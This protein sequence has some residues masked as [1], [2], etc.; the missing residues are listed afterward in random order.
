MATAKKKS[1]SKKSAP[2]AKKSALKKSAPKAKKSAPKVK[3]KPS[4]KQIAQRAKIG[5]MGKTYTAA[6]NEK[7]AGRKVSAAD[8]A[9]AK[10]AGRR[11][12]KAMK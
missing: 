12:V 6:Y 11:A 8:I 5:K 2:K 9:N 1:S 4:A 7:L 3:A 10:A